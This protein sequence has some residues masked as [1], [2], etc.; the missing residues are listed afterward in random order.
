MRTIL[1]EGWGFKFNTLE[2]FNLFNENEEIPEISDQDGVADGD[3]ETA[4]EGTDNRKETGLGEGQ[5]PKKTGTRGAD[6]G[7]KTDEEVPAILKKKERS[8]EGISEK[9]G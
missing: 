6:G 7:G 4:G 9:N 8:D 3:K 1:S 2:E 5:K